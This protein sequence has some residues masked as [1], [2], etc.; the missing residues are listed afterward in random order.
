MGNMKKLQ[1]WLLLGVLL[2]AS[3]ARISAEPLS[4]LPREAAAQLPANHPLAPVVA[5]LS[6]GDSK[7]ARDLLKGPLAAKP[8][9][10]LTHEL[11]GFMRA[12]AG[13]LAGAEAAF[14]RAIAID[15]KPRVTN[16]ALGEVLFLQGKYQEARTEFSRYLQVSPGDAKTHIFLGRLAMLRGEPRQAITHFERFSAGPD[17]IA[18]RARLQ[19]ALLEANLGN[20]L[21]AKELLAGC[22]GTCQAI[23]TYLLA[24]AELDRV[25]GRLP[26]AEAKLEQLARKDPAAGE[27]WLQ[28]GALRQARGDVSGAE[29]AFDMAARVPQ[30][31]PVATLAAASS[32]LARKDPR[33]IA[34]L[35]ELVTQ[36]Q[37]PEAYILLAEGQAS[38]GKT[39]ESG[40]TLRTLV[41]DHPN[42]AQG[43]LM[44][45]LWYLG[46]NQSPRAVP[47]L[48]T[49]IKL[50]PDLVQG[51]IHLA[52]ISSHAHH[53]EEAEN[54]LRTG[55]KHA[56]LNS[57]LPYYLG[58][59][60]EQQGRWADAERA[61]AAAIKLR[62]E[63]AFAMNNRARMLVRTGGDLALAEEMMRKV[64]G[65]APK[66]P[67]AL[68][69]LGW[70]LVNRGKMKEAL[71]LLQEAVKAAPENPE[72]HY[73]IS[74]TLEKL[75]RPKEAAD[76]LRIAHE[77]GLPKDYAT[78]Q[79][80]HTR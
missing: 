34:A 80:A 66:D 48:R 67:L 32:M 19:I 35:T 71:P 27:V 54:L 10:A 31:R 28:L 8:P 44:L 2:M 78:T 51:W 74:V 17:P 55:M 12:E 64:V 49:A 6:K 29:Q 40:Q 63:F 69:N 60:L 37:L 23:P 18:Q 61:Y 33:A 41:N 4:W 39:V 20:T 73:Y 7:T 75:G 25:E 47:S 56:P 1:R 68:A 45:G 76:R 70:V 24:Q 62:P 46:Q 15:A 5:A 58:L 9:L 3:V 11:D 30:Y 43:H 50:Q 59:E 72:I 36:K 16:A 53:S 14:R 22:S 57:E 79:G 65:Q 26:A 13:D 42:F 21:K 52:D 77:R 38:G